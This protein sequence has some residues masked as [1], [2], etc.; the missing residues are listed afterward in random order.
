[1]IAINNGPIMKPCI[2][3]L[4]LTSAVTPLLPGQSGSKKLL[5]ASI[6]LSMIACMRP[7]LAL[8]LYIHHNSQVLSYNSPSVAAL[9]YKAIGAVYRMRSGYQMFSAFLFL[10]IIKSASSRRNLS[11][12]SSISYV[13]M[14]KSSRA[15]YVSPLVIFLTYN[16][17]A[18][19]SESLIGFY[20]NFIG[21]LL[22]I[23]ISTINY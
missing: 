15:S 1:M 21:L 2:S 9:L 22:S 10:W 20:L 12:E 4:K 11:F 18:I 6:L 3:V 19:V 23:Y 5:R 16:R 8:A 7:K 17:L 14:H 13:L